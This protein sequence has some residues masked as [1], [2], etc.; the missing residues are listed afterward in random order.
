MLP[1]KEISIATVYDN[2]AVD[3]RLAT[4]WGFAAVISTPDEIVLFDTGGDAATLLSNMSI[5]GIEP[6]DISTVV[7][8]HIHGDHIGGLQGFLEANPKVRVFIPRSFPDQ[9]RDMIAG[10][11]AEYVDVEEPTLVAP[12]IHTTGPLGTSLEEQALV[13]ETGEGL[14]VMTGCA[15]PGIVAMVDE[16]QSMR[17]QARIALVMGGFHLGSAS[18]EQIEEI[19]RSLREAGI[20]R[21]AP[22]HCTGDAARSRFE[23]AFGSD[24]VAGGLGLILK[25]APQ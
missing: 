9:V 6:A 21:V 16:A 19:V 10:A 4:G 25:F 8:S 15:H 13:V 2:Y 14:V 12:R 22:S 5:L 3:A 23:A 7:I 11:G 1:D 18:R 17:P 24:Y 20:R